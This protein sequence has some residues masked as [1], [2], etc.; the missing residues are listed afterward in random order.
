MEVLKIDTQNWFATEVDR[1]FKT[2]LYGDGY[3]LYLEVL[4]GEYLLVEG[5]SYENKILKLKESGG[6]IIE[7]SNEPNLKLFEDT[8]FKDWKEFDEKYGQYDEDRTD[9]EPWA[10]RSRYA[11]AQELNLVEHNDNVKMYHN[12]TF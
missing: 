4:N 7:I 1:D 5:I 3:R 10:Y 12:K 8:I 6:A 2:K 9:Y 11:F